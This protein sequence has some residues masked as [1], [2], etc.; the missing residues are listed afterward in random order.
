M[1][2]KLFKS[3]IV[4]WFGGMMSAMAMEPP[5]PSWHMKRWASRCTKR[6]A[7]EIQT[8]LRKF[9]MG[10]YLYIRC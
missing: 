2:V 9:D 3:V 7:S 4:A 1:I 5:L 8:I 6:F 10:Y